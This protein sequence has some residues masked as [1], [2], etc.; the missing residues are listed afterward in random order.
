MFIE[1]LK[2]VPVFPEII[3]NTFPVQVTIKKYVYIS[4][5]S[6]ISLKSLHYQ[7]IEGLREPSV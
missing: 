3:E 6:Q 4:Q 1:P 2:L 5:I 7:M